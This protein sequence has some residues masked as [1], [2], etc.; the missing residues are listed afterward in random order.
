MKEKRA[1]KRVSHN[2]GESFFKFMVR[3]GN[4]H[5]YKG[6]KVC[7]YFFKRPLNYFVHLLAQFMP[8]TRV[9]VFLHKSRGVR[10]GPQVQIGAHVWIDESFP[11]YVE[12][13]KNASLAL[14]CRVVAHSI[15]HAFHEGRFEAY[16]SPV[17]IKEGAWIGMCSIVLPGVT[18]GK[19]SVVSAG[20]VVTQDVPSFTIVRGNPAEIV[21]KVRMR[22]EEREEIKNSE[23]N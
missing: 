8:Y 5:G 11:N 2:K 9:R 1:K 6:I 4:E 13:E 10:I 3:S 17:L 16:V 18:I 7:C 12:I 23:A 14:G 20:S 15:P 22:L 21:G 19:G